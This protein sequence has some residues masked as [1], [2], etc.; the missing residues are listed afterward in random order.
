MAPGVLTR[1]FDRGRAG[2][3]RLRGR[4]TATGA[5]AAGPLPAIGGADARAGEVDRSASREELTA[6]RLS[7]ASELDRL[8]LR[9]G[10]ARAGPSR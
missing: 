3:R 2:A 5:E 6:L 8:A 9:E 10:S 7:L 1:V 4:A